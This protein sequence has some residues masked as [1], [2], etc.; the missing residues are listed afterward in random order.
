MFDTRLVGATAVLLTTIAGIG[1]L[2]V[3]SRPL[4]FGTV[5]NAWLSAQP[6]PAS[7]PTK[8][9]LIVAIGEQG[10]P[11]DDTHGWPTLD[12]ASNSVDLIH[13]TLDV[14]EFDAIAVLR[15]ADATRDGILEAFRTH[16]L[17]PALP[18]DIAVF[19]YS[20]HGSQLPDDEQGEENDGEDEV[21]VPYG[22]PDPA[23]LDS[24]E[25][26]Q[27]E[28]YFVRDDTLG[29]LLDRLASKV[30][31]DGQV[32][33]F[34]DACHSGTGTRGMA[35]SAGP[36]FLPEYAPETGFQEAP[37][38][39]RGASDPHFITIS[40]GRHFEQVSEREST[41]GTVSPLAHALALTLPRIQE[42]S[43]FRDLYDLIS[44]VARAENYHHAPQLEGPDSLAVFQNLFVPYKPWVPV[45]SVLDSL[46]VK[47]AGGLLQGFTDSSE[48]QLHEP[49]M[50]GTLNAETLWNSGIV[51]GATPLRA[52]VRL[53]SPHRGEEEVQR[54]RAFLTWQDLGDMST[55]VRI[56]DEVDPTLARTLRQE[57]ESKRTVSVVDTGA[58]AVVRQEGGAWWL[59]TAREGAREGNIVGEPVA[60]PSDGDLSD[61][62]STISRF[63]RY[64]YLR[65]L[66]F[67]DSSVDVELRMLP[68]TRDT[69]NAKCIAAEADT[70]SYSNDFSRANEDGS[71]W[72]VQY[73]ENGDQFFVL[74][75]RNTNPSRRAFVTIMDFL[76]NGVVKPLYPSRG[77][78]P[79][80]TRLDPGE[81]RPLGCFYLSPEQGDPTV[82]PGTEIV[83]LFATNEAVDFRPYLT[84]ASARE[85][86]RLVRTDSEAQADLGRLL[87]VMFDDGAETRT[88]S[89]GP[90]ATKVS[91]SSVRINIHLDQE[92]R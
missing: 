31:S 6:A 27:Y 67:Q 55:R 46:T 14:H 9:A 25:I 28:E 71:E 29:A 22:A 52:F 68:A 2:L 75:I 5:R 66:N 49:G 30:G 45:D 18:G 44:E 79:T 54:G 64:T 90:I 24:T 57:L 1:A 16:L 77:Q 91:V 58:D 36:V 89:V 60:V 86:A 4:R 39:T 80:D 92:S 15:D 76:P 63:S 73:R 34:L 78:T 13:G 74:K 43:S 85:V 38:R 70:L 59:A 3:D 17:D 37:T 47:I 69:A 41:R 23:W 8:R 7:I 21:L 20:G 87:S 35:R 33:A 72:D 12:G 83:K 65:R 19:Y 10:D 88:R 81:E 53:D 26:D 32:V 42:R 48:V 56:D 51:I 82:S 84:S 11:P 40:A 61:L 62:T 50:S